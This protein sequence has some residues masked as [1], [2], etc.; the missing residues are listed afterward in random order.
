MKIGGPNNINPDAIRVVSL[1]DE[2]SAGIVG[3]RVAQTIAA[4]VFESAIECAQPDAQ[5]IDLDTARKRLR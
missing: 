5:I 3:R 2:D 4:T 1:G